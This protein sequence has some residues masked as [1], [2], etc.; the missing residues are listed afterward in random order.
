MSNSSNVLDVIVDLTL[1]VAGS[2][3]TRLTG[4]DTLE[5]A[6]TPEILQANLQFA[7]TGRSTNEGGI[8]TRMVLL[9]LLAHARQFALRPHPTVGCGLDALLL[10]A[11]L[12]AIAH[13]CVLFSVCIKK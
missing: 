5:N 6:Q 4:I 3:T 13:D 9:L 11:A 7:Q 2:S 8:N 12:D 1:F 10:H